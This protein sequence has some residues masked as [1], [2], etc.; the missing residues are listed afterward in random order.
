MFIYMGKYRNHYST[1]DWKTP[2]WFNDKAQTVINFCFNSWYTKLNR[3]TFVHVSDHDT[4]NFAETLAPIILKGLK[5]LNKQGAP[6]V[7][8]DDVPEELKSTS[9]P[10]LENPWDTDEFWHD[11]WDYVYTQMVWSF[12]QLIDDSWEDQFHS[13]VMDNVMVPCEDGSGN[14]WMTDGPNHTWKFDQEGCAAYNDRIQ[15]G[16]RLFGKYYRGLWD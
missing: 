12:E 9:A 14:F 8:D 15:N 16:L 10:P 7:D 11:R 1:Y 3:P 5:R 13:G 6:H 2:E 4:W